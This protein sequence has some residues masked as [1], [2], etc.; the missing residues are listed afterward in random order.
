[1]RLGAQKYTAL[2][3]DNGRYREAADNAEMEA[4]VFKALLGMLNSKLPNDES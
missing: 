4:F 1:M 3:D 2:Q